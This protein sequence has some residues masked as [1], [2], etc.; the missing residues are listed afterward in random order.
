MSTLNCEEEYLLS[1]KILSF[2]KW[3]DMVRF[4]RTGGEANAIAVRIARAS[5]RKT[6]HCNLWI[7]WMARLVF[8]SKYKK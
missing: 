3:A 4:A 2:T 7:S 6:E 5:Y 8:V 1:E